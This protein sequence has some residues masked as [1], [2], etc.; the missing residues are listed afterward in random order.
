MRKTLIISIT[1]LFTL[2]CTKSSAPAP[3]GEK[4]AKTPAAKE[5]APPAKPAAVAK[6]AAPAE[7]KAEPPKAKP[8]PAPVAGD[9]PA[10]PDVAAPPAD[11]AKT[12]TGLASKV[13]KP[14]SGKKHPAAADT[15]RVHY[16]GWTTDGKMFDSSVTRGREQNRDD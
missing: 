1:L 8:A 9:I 14:G 2:S 11:A 15:V 6:A 12:P 4:A 13:I 10:P 7:K 16:S 3:S 5:A